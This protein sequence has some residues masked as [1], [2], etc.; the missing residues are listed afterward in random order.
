ML[1]LGFG[2]GCYGFVGS[3]VPCGWVGFDGVFW[4]WFCWVWVFG[5]V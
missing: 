3:G 5:F 4:F 2:F 1:G